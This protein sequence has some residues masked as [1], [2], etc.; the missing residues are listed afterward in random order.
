MK[1]LEALKVT[2]NQ[3]GDWIPLS[4]GSMY[5]KFF[6]A[7][8]TKQGTGTPAYTMKLQVSLDG[9]NA[10]DL[11]TVTNSDADGSVKVMGDAIPRPAAFM[12]QVFSGVTLNGATSLTGRICASA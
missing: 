5:P 11:L 10:T 12:R 9:V 8:V 1:Y 6:S 4:A 3:T 7:S 2:G